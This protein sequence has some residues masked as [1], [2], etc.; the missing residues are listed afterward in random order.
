M[1]TVRERNIAFAID[2]ANFGTTQREAAAIWDLP[3]S[4][5]HGRLHGATS[6]TKALLHTRRLSPLQETFLVNYCLHEE[7]SGRAPSK[8]RVRRWAQLILAEGGVFETIGHR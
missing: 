7:A 6:K 1:T 5:L 3:Q 2:E 8:A 4:T